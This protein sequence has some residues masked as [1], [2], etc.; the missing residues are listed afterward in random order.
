MDRVDVWLAGALL[1]GADSQKAATAF[2][3][4]AG[5]RPEQALTLLNSG[6]PRLVK[7]DLSLE[8]GRAYVLQL[9]A[10]GIG[11]GLRP[12]GAPAPAAVP[13]AQAQAK[14]A[15]SGATAGMSGPAPPSRAPSAPRTPRPVWP[16]SPPWPRPPGARWATPSSSGA[17]TPTPPPTYYEIGRASCRERV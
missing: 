12:S 16:S 6:R 17:T 5:L 3:R 1:P 9:R 13:E 11:S 8:Q 4:A 14:P 10:L 15:P 7:R 2:A